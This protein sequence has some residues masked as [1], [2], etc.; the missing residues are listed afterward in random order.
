MFNVPKLN[1]NL[2]FSNVN[3]IML[4]LG[5]FGKPIWFEK[6]RDEYMACRHG[7]AIIDMSSFTKF[8]I[9]SAGRK[10]V[11]F[12]QNICSNDIDSPIG[13]VIH[14]GMQNHKGGYENDCSVVQLEPNKYICHNG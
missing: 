12:L 1:K 13:H 5:S 4:N 10:V 8:E 3:I 14:T 7:V 11:D 9:K 6:V 2:I